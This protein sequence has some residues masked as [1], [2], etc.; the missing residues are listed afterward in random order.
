MKKMKTWM[1]T[2]IA[3]LLCGAGFWYASSN[4]YFRE[5]PQTEEPLFSLS[6]DQVTGISIKQ[7]G[8]QV[9]LIYGD[10]GWQMV[11]PTYYPLNAYGADTWVEGFIGLA[12]GMVI[13][14]HAVDIEKYGLSSPSAVY[15]VTKNNGDTIKLEIGAETPVSGEVYARIGGTGKVLAL[16]NSKLSVL[17]KGAFDFTAKEPFEYVSNQVTEMKWTWN[18][19]TYEAVK[20]TD[21]SGKS[22]GLTWSLN[23]KT[24]EETDLLAWLNKVRFLT[25]EQLPRL[26]SDLKS[27]ASALQFSITMDKSSSGAE[28]ELVTKNYTG[29]VEDDQVWIAAEG[30]IWAI[31][32]Q[33]SEMDQL[34]QELD[35]LLQPTE[36]SSSE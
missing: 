18:D 17:D 28:Q 15:E 34:Q 26:V 16:E 2:L 32:L 33:T 36:T 3:V 10:D 29:Y 19:H 5:Q 7:D 1:P 9:K 24:A 14:E 4:D 21:S 25:A 35:T 8:E 31:P 13:E 12:A 30:S 27:Q 11:L 23:G 20:Q 6:A 22:T